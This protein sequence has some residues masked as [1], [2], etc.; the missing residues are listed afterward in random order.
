VNDSVRDLRL[1]ML[2]RLAPRHLRFVLRLLKE[3]RIPFPWSEW[4]LRPFQNNLPRGA[5]E[6]MISLPTEADAGQAA[7]VLEKTGQRLV[8]IG[9]PGFP[10]ELQDIPDPPPFLFTQGEPFRE[11]KTQRVGVVGSR[12]ASAAGREI[13]FGLGRDLALAGCVVVSGLA[14][15]IDGWAHRGALEGGGRTVAVLGTGADV[16]YPPEHAGLLRDV[17]RCGGV[18]TEFPPGTPGLRLHFPRRNRI[19]AGLCS[20][21]VVVEGG[22][23]SGARSTVDHALDQGCEVMAVPRDILHP[24]SALPNAMIRDGAR[25]VLASRDVLE[26]LAGVRSNHSSG[27]SPQLAV[28]A[29]AASTAT[30][31]QVAPQVAFPG[32]TAAEARLLAGLRR[33]RLS[34]DGLLGLWPDQNVGELQATLLRLELMGW[35]ARQDGG[36]YQVTD[37][38]RRRD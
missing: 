22:E 28:R 21:L 38:T 11:P 16:C 3:E 15:G 36:Y 23:R 6:L 9:C 10:R 35:I 20:A 5:Y 32:V 13:A 33:G 26:A 27:P 1:A 31:T 37:R 18:V 8:K 4:N 14:R 2:W 17:L 25:P 30:V 12:A 29:T 24:G 19:L 34:L 7:G